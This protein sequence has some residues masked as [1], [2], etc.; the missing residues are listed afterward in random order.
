MKVV[1]SATSMLIALMCRC[2]ALRSMLS[3]G[4]RII[5]TYQASPS[6]GDGQLARQPSLGCAI[7]FYLDVYAYFS[8]G[9][10]RYFWPF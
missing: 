7:T 2:G 3:I 5:A 4:I 6:C 9:P 1:A 10:A 8:A